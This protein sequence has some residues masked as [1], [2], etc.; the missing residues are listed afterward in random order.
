MYSILN[1]GRYNNK[2]TLPQV[3][4]DD[5]D[6]FFWATDT[7]FFS[8]RGFP[9]ASDLAYKARNIKIPKSD[10]EHWGVL[11][12]F[13]PGTNIFH[14]FKLVHN[15]VGKE[16]PGMPGFLWEPP[17]GLNLSIV[18]QSKRHDKVGNECLL[19][20]FKLHYFG[21]EHVNLSREN[22][23]EFFDCAANFCEFPRLKFD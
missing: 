5:P 17:N 18:Y 4:L 15:P 22:C 1:F 14:G 10:A 13:A 12:D 23:E 11:Y 21:Y 8:K 7:H 16:I 2:M 6:Y 19:R 9:E 20:D 3:V